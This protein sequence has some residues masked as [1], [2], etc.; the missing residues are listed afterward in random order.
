VLA[1]ANQVPGV[2]ER[3]GLTRAQ[4]DLAAWAIEPGGTRFEGA[5]AVNRVLREMG[6]AWPRLASAYQARP[7]A[8]VEEAIYRWFARNRWRFG[9]FGVRPEC[10]G[11]SSPCGPPG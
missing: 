11:P 5:A 7:V 4:V 2:I 3:F 8:F 6:G 10:D 1:V 9:R